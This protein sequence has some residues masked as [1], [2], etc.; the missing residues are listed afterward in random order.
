MLESEYRKTYELE[1]TF[2]W[3]VAKRE[4]SQ[5]YAGQVLG[6]LWAIGHPLLLMGLYVFVFAYIFRLRLNLSEEM[7]RG[8]AIYIL[9]GLIPW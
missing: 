1:R 9:C 6:T 3:F 5:R 7:P 8:A 2:W 4:I